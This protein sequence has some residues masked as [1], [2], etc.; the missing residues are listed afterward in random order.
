MPPATMYPSSSGGGMVSQDER[1]QAMLMWILCIVASFFGLP[2]LPPLIFFLI[3]KD[4]PFVYRHAAMAL[5]LCLVAF[6]VCVILFVTVVG[7][8]LIPIVGIFELI[9]CIMGAI[10]AN[11]GDEYDPPLFA[12]LA[13]S[14][15]KV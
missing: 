3:S 12:G 5:S 8:I 11:K 14:M 6:V 1:S 4:K 10:A 7:I 2:W 15:F 9:I 13:K